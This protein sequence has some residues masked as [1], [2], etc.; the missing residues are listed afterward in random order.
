ME[1]YK[2]PGTKLRYRLLTALLFLPVLFWWIYWRWEW[3]FLVLVTTMVLLGMREYFKMMRQKGISCNY[4]LG[5]LAAALM[6]L[7]FKKGE[8]IYPGLLLTAM[9]MAVL[10]RQIFIKSDIPAVIQ[11]VSATFLGIVYVGWMPAHLL[12]LKSLPD[13]NNLVFF[14]FAVTWLGDALAYFVGSL[15]GRHKLIASISPNKTVE[16]TIAGVLGS[17]LAAFL[18]FEIFKLPLEHRLFY[19]TAGFIV[20][21][22][23]VFGDLSESLL[24]RSTRIKDASTII[25]G[26]GGILDRFDSI[27]FT[28]PVM[29]YLCWFFL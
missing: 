12:A 20:G 26:H 15:F 23:A 18:F 13:G 27:F 4:I 1:D 25:P 6:P 21:V 2:E 16:G 29:Y 5:Y 28:A 19:L 7:V 8:L 22:V 17:I 3:P 9:C 14:V 10:I 24:K 11:T